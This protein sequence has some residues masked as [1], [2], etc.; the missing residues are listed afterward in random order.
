MNECVAGGRV[1]EKLSMDARERGP[2]ETRAGA[3]ARRSSECV[4][5]GERHTVQKAA[6]SDSN[7]AP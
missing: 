2:G 4:R 3:R 7:F 6:V 1:H 5:D